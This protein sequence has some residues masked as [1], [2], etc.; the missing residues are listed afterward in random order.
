M[1]V[2]RGDSCSAMLFIS[3]KE[4]T[5][6]WV[7]RAPVFF[8]SRCSCVLKLFKTTAMVYY[9]CSLLRLRLYTLNS[10]IFEFDDVKYLKSQSFNCFFYETGNVRHSGLNLYSSNIHPWPCLRQ[11][12]L[13]EAVAVLTFNLCYWL[14]I[15]LLRV[16][17]T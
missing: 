10:Q 5:K 13:L 12:G 8:P 11:P 6:F 14:L 16:V 17:D 3:G 4:T 1:C 9:S 2:K 7:R 15:M